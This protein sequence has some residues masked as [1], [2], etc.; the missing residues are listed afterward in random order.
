MGKFKIL[1]ISATIQAMKRSEL[2]IIKKNNTEILQI[3]T[4]DGLNMVFLKN[5]CNKF[6]LMGY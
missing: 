3:F 5:K 4:V 6:I 2:I 1:N